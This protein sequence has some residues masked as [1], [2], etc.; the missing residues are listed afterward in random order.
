M[1]G[2]DRHNETG[3]VPG[4]DYFRPTATKLFDMAAIDSI[5]GN[6]R[7]VATVAKGSQA[8][9]HRAAGMGT[10]PAPAPQA[11]DAEQAG[12][13]M[14]REAMHTLREAMHTLREWPAQ[15][16]DD[17]Q[18]VRIGELLYQLVALE[19]DFSVV[20]LAASLPLSV[21]DTPEL[22]LQVLML[23]SS[24]YARLGVSG[25]VEADGGVCVVFSLPGSQSDAPLLA[26]ALRVLH[27]SSL[28][29][30][31]RHVFDRV[32]CNSSARPIHEADRSARA[33]RR[34]CRGRDTGGVYLLAYA[35][36]TAA[37]GLA[38]AVGSSPQTAPGRRV[39][40]F[41]LA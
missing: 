10:A 29:H 6:R 39:P 31:L 30:D 16:D 14:L 22:A 24:L 19:D 26:H 27:L 13:Q 21:F 8:R 5:D 41:G 40:R 20:C 36:A 9:G 3:T 34:R 35:A 12:R 17:A 37:A 38:V 28:W 11:C 33:W 15:W 25:C 2:R 32:R 7:P 18:G 23:N 4:I 1:P